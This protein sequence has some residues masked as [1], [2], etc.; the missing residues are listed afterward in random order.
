VQPGNWLCLCT[1][2]YVCMCLCLSVSISLYLC[3]R[4]TQVL[5]P[6]YVF[7]LFSV[8]V[9][10]AEEYYYYAGAIVAIS[11][12]SI[13]ASLQE[14]RAVRRTACTWSP[15]GVRPCGC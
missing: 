3:A 8:A 4:G 10:A 15:R 11:V 7:Q 6:F 9:W 2:K 1:Y 12:F 14:T 5:H 13:L